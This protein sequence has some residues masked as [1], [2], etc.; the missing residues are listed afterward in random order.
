MSNRHLE[1]DETLVIHYGTGK[2]K[3]MGSWTG[4]KSTNPTSEIH[5]IET[6]SEYKKRLKPLNK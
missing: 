2:K 3:W 6:L 1:K 5:N 4:F